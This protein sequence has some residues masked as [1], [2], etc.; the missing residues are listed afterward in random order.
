MK[1]LLILSHVFSV[2]LISVS[3]DQNKMA[4]EDTESAGNGICSAEEF[5]NHVRH[6]NLDE[7]QRCLDKGYNLETTLYGNSPLGEAVAY[8]A[9]M[10]LLL[11]KGLD[12]N[13][14]SGGMS[15][16]STAVVAGNAPV[17]VVALLIKHGADPN[18]KD[19]TGKSP[20]DYATE[21][22]GSGDD[23]DPHYSEKLSVLKSKP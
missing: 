6:G 17:E 15:P 10:K 1:K 9:V 20:I 19:A 3:C 2:C 18:L 5:F 21:F 16:L 22:A 23:I 11:E 13:P 8:P 4:S 12:P 14:K 7:I